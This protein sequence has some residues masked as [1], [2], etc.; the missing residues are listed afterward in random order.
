MAAEPSIVIVG[1][2]AAGLSTAVELMERGCRDVSVIDRGHVASG[3]SM[4][5]AG[6]FTR[7]Y[8]DPVDIALRQEAYEGLCRLERETGLVLRRNG[9]VR[10]AHDDATMRSFE[11]A[12]E[13]Q[14]SLGIHDAR[15]LDPDE[16]KQLIP[17]LFV[18]DLTGG[19]YGPSDGYLDGQQLCMTYAE[20]AQA[21]GARVLPRH[22]LLGYERGQRRR[23]RLITSSAV[24]ECDLVVNAAGAW[25]PEVG[26]ILGAPLPI[27]AERHQACTFQLSGSLTY[28]LPSVMDYIPGSGEAGLYLRPE[29][30]HQIIAG[31]HTNDLVEDGEDPNAYYGGVDASFVDE[32][33]PLLL[34]R[35]PGF[36]DVGLHGGWAGLYP[37]SPDEQFIIGP[38]ADVDGVFA[39]GG[40]NGLG[41]YMSPVVGR[42]TAD[43]LLGQTPTLPLAPERFLPDRLRSLPDAN[44]VAR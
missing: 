27:V 18:A 9:F 39:A 16:L 41:V 36:E 12:A 32:L 34:R 23:H 37:N 3:S 43:W 7:Q 4:L 8:I 42:V 30:E 21:M 40:L 11:G 5:S 2:G 22:E 28:V 44:K 1:A 14:R 13:V 29:G 10:L 35:A 26:E 20:R 19:L 17:D 6:I 15:T 33:I 24:L 25:A 31:L 38:Y